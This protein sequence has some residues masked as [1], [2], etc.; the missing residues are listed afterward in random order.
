MALA[1]LAATLASG[2]ASRSISIAQETR[3]LRAEDGFTLATHALFQW[4]GGSLE[5]EAASR[6][7]SGVLV[8]VQ[9][10]EDTTVSSVAEQLAGACAMGLD[11]IAVERRGVTPDGRVDQAIARRYC[12]KARRVADERLL[13]ADYLARH[14]AIT[15]H[16]MPIIVMG[17]SEGADVAAALAASEGRVTHLILIAGGGG[18]SQADEFRHLLAAHRMVIPGATTA[19]ELEARFG[20]IRAHPD[21]DTPWFGHPYRRWA[22]FLF[23]RPSDDLIRLS[24]PILAIHGDADQSVPVESA[25]A[26]RDRFV[27][28]GRANLRL[29]EYPGVDHRLMDVATGTTVRPWV[30]LDAIAWLASQGALPEEAAQAF[31]SRVLAAHPELQLRR[32]AEAGDRR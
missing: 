15:E 11:V 17:A 24:I 19:D 27:A 30:E 5:E 6:S 8:Y 14:P 16:A 23:D 9:G 7:P 21:A 12:T 2:C 20:D 32:D 28:E 22:S 18:W 26:L 10:S 3:P 1:W 31:T 13:V 25:R 4:K 29:L